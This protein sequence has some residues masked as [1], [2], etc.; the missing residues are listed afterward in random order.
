MQWKVLKGAWHLGFLEYIDRQAHRQL[1]G[2][3]LSCSFFL[4]IAI[5]L[6]QLFVCC[7]LVGPEY[8]AL[9]LYER[10]KSAYHLARRF[11]DQPQDRE[12]Y[13][14]DAKAACLK[15]DEKKFLTWLEHIQTW[16]PSSDAK[17]P[18]D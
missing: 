11:P 1:R 4:T 7:Q 12:T 10:S 8:Q 16:P 14:V 5:C 15:S 2:E 6:A 13:I 3:P 9:A 17:G 18:I